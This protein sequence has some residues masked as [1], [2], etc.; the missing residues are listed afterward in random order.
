MANNL[1]VPLVLSAVVTLALL[2][3]VHVVPKWYEQSRT[4]STVIRKLDTGIWRLCDEL[5]V[6]IVG[7]SSR[8]CKAFDITTRKIHVYR[9]VRAA[10]AF[11]I[12]ATVFAGL[13]LISTLIIEFD[14]TKVVLLK[15]PRIFFA[16]SGFAI[17]IAALSFVAFISQDGEDGDFDTSRH[18]FRVTN[19]YGASFII[20]WVT[21][22]PAYVAGLLAHFHHS[23]KAAAA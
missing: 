9:G 6:P 11:A 15:L 18:G 19:K 16:V 21:L 8:A 10:Q 5:N 2:I 1:I 7:F 13:G 17:A 20:A 4:D 22:V 23:A 12:I 3:T 14:I